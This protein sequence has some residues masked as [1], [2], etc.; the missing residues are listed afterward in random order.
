M[1]RL[2]NFFKD[3]FLANGVIWFLCGIA[4]IIFKL[5]FQ[6]R[7]ILLTLIFPLAYAIV[8]LFDLTKSKPAK[9]EE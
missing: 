9:S 7:E 4:I 6:V 1:K 3:F 2:G 8:R 5:N